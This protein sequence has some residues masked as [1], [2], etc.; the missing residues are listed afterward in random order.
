M[1]PMNRAS[2]YARYSTDRQ[3]ARSIDDQI[4]RCRAYADGHGLAL[5]GT[6]ADAALS[7]AHR[8]RPEM[9]R[10]LAD[11][12]RGAFAVVLVDDLS[13]LSRDLG[14]TW[15][16]VFEELAAH[17]VRVIDV[18][19]GMASDGAGARLTFG[20]MALVNDTFLQLVRAETHRGM[21][22][23]AIAGFSTGGRTYGYASVA[24]ESPPDPEHPRRRL[25]V[26]E[27]EATVV[28]AIFRAWVEGKALKAIAAQLNSDGIAAP[29]DRGNGNKIGRGW[30]HSTV[31][32]ILANERYTGRVTWN[33]SK[34]VRVPG[35]RSRRRV[36]RPES[37]WRV[38]DVPELRVIDDDTFRAAQRRFRKGRGR[39]E[40]TAK[41]PHLLTGLLICG[42]CGG[43]MTIVSG[44]LKAGVRY[45][46]F[47]CTSYAQRGAAICG[48]NRTVG[49]RKITSAVLGA[50]GRELDRPELLDRF[51]TA[52]RR[53]RLRIADAGRKGQ[54]DA[55]RALREAET[56]LQNVTDAMAR[57]GWS[58]AL[59]EQLRQEEERVARAR[60]MAAPA[61]T[62][63]PRLPE[64]AELHAHLRNM[65]GMLTVDAGRGRAI[66]QRYLAPMHC[67]PM[68]TGGYRA[69]G[70]FDLALA[71]GLP[72]PVMA[73]GVCGR[74]G[75][76]GPH[77]DLPR[78]VEIVAIAR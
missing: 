71:A 50:L 68:A 58:S 10:M 13:R 34:W 48:N 15:R 26:D 59:A 33:T 19:T 42:V 16:I 31:R 30:P 78:T 55:V 4:R 60:M 3:D 29:H 23:R 73:T 67:T 8:D 51:V 43:S 76:G 12:E 25:V 2:I 38:L 28:R 11:A 72:P 27:V 70:N 36:D 66:L 41:S 5:A 39:V 54:H 14:N 63:L 1:T 57:V 52:F 22:G 17:G 7:G 75:S 18:T 69:V 46:N 6:Y 74:I 77:D 56:R 44:K 45:A 24:E 61:V 9:Q 32:A 40:G 65:V 47:G 21:E 49:E 64:P 37:E 62:P 35:K 20:A 53:H